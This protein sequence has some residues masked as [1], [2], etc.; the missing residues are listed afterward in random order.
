TLTG[1]NARMALAGEA[2]AYQFDVPHG[3]HS[4]D[5]DV[6]VRAA[7]YQLFGI[8]ADPNMSP[9]DAQGTA[10][11]DGSPTSL[12]TMHL[13]WANP[14]PGR[15]SLNLVTFFGNQSLLTS[16]P[17]GGT[18]SFD[19]TAITASGL[20]DS[21][22]STLPRGTPATAIIHVT[23]SGKSPELYSVDPRLNQDSVLSLTSATKTS[24]TLPLDVA[25]LATIPQF[26]VPPFSTDLEI[27]AA[28][29]VPINFTTSPTFGTPEI[30]S[31]THGDNAIV[32][33][34]APD[35]AASL[36]SC[37]PTEI[38][39]GPSVAT[40]F[41]CGAAA[42]TKTFDLA[43]DSSTGN[44]WSAL[45]GLT[46]TYNPLLLQPGQ[47]RDITV[48][49]TPT[50]PTGTVVSG[51]LAVESFNFNTISSDQ[52]AMIPYRYTVG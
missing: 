3:V 51:F 10:L 44:I 43:V 52:F 47:S 14:M 32:T 37:P 12:Q 42:T 48:T 11:P 41:S 17:I 2:L 8:L 38:G 13:T 6:K 36:W 49:I 19:R 30:G 26:V 15:W 28:S 34:S 25:Q 5:V 31:V 24:G 1:G 20:P 29:T 33:Y 9:V 7:G 22:S 16:V 45:E 39:P 23:N 40:V 18:I 35:I 4:I 50:A 27:A 46:A 21:K